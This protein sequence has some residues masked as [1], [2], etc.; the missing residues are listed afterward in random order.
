M[1][2]K[3]KLLRHYD[4]VKGILDGEFLAPVMADVDT[5]SGIC[6]LDCVWCMQKVS[7]AS[8][9]PTF[10]S[11]E[12]MKRLGSFSREWGIKSW[13]LAGDSEPTLNENIDYLLKSGQENGIDMGLIT[14]GTLLWRVKELGLLTWLGISLDA[15]DAETWSRLKNSPEENF[16]NIIKHIKNVRDELPDLDISIKFVRWGDNAVVAS[17]LAETLGVNCII[18]EP[19]PKRDPYRFEK[20]L[21]T[22]LGINFGADHEARLCCDVRDK[23][24]LTKD[25]TKNDWGELPALWGSEK[26]KKLI[27][28][29]KPDKC[30]FCSHDW[31]N[32]IIENIILDGKYT[33]RN[34][35][36]FI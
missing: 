24:L 29:I 12:T 23:F 17:Y 5:V 14:N 3:I 32:T 22:P 16:I 35:V 7:R 9:K 28:S 31:C 33:E 15:T 8:K 27:A 21:C 25:Y 1:D 30:T 6:N 4:R 19:L 11:L 18:R 10:M 34:Q 20:C 36:N 2:E 26:H 13:R